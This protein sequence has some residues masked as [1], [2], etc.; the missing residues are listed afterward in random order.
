MLTPFAN[1]F[2]K[3][4]L[5]WFLKTFIVIM[6]PVFLLY[7]FKDALDDLKYTFKEIDNARNAK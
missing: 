7:Y 2:I 1:W 6:F 3:N 5:T 4:R